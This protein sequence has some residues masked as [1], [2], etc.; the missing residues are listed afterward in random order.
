MDALWHMLNALALP[1]GVAAFS[2]LGARLLWRSSAAACGLLSLLGWAYMPAV[3]A[4]A[5]AWA[6]V[7][8]EGTMI[9]YAVMVSATALGL[10][11][12][13]FGPFRPPQLAKT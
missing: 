13:L 1:F 4:H 8:A 5:V 7:G 9:G 2:A 10:W 11:C 12:R 3:V 6:V